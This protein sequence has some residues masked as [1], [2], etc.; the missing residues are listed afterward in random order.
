MTDEFDIKKEALMQQLP[1]WLKS[2]GFEA[3][4]AFRG[5]M[6]AE[7]GEA[8]ASGS[9]KAGKSGDAFP[10]KSATWSNSAVLRTKTGQL[11]NS[12]NPGNNYTATEIK[13]EGYKL[14]LTIGSRLPYAGAHETGAFIATKGRMHKW[15]WAKYM[16][17]NNPFFKIMALSVMKR[18]GVLIKSRPY[19]APAL[20][21]FQ[22]EYMQKWLNGIIDKIA[23]AL[24]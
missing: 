18:G 11:L 7:M 3:V 14:N 15:F 20:S 17:S 12:F 21:K 16:S 5:Y 4:V 9:W 6:G 10:D 24:T 22:N 19:F 13:P 23:K 1:E 8:A 2:F